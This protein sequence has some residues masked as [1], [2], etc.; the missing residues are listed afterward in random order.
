MLV[1]LHGD[2][3]D[4]EAHIA[5]IAAWVLHHAA[6]MNIYRQSAIRSRLH[7]CDIE[8]AIKDPILAYTDLTKMLTSTTYVD[9]QIRYSIQFGMRIKRRVALDP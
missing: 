8:G 5:Y 4:L 1:S 9:D 3:H 6:R 2:L 7:P